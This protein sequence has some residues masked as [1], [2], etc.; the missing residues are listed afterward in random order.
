[1]AAAAAVQRQL[2]RRGPKRRRGRL[3][4]DKTGNA[5]RRRHRPRARH[6]ELGAARHM[7]ATGPG[8]SN[9]GDDLLKPVRGVG[10][11]LLGGRSEQFAQVH[12]PEVFRHHST[13]PFVGTR[14]HVADSGRT[15]SSE[16]SSPSGLYAS[17]DTMSYTVS[18]PTPRPGPW[19]REQPVEDLRSWAPLS[20]RADSAFVQK[21]PGAPLTSSTVAGSAGIH[22]VDPCEPNADGAGS[23]EFDQGGC[24]DATVRCPRRRSR[25]R[26]S[27][28]RRLRS[29]SFTVR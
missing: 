19:L 1:M 22:D 24:G 4:G 26:R 29:A 12:S 6:K 16:P 2:R 10:G 28:P 23:A 14:D 3:R 8:R 15:T 27:S 13:L 11:G 25:S 18:F 9:R 5:R 20:G 17:D 21:E 7:R